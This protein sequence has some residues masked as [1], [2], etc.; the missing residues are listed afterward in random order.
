LRA[1]LPAQLAAT[2]SSGLE[3]AQHAR[4]QHR[5]TMPT[6]VGAIDELLGGG[7]PKGSLVELAARRSAG[8]FSIVLQTIAAATSAGEAAAL[9]DLGDHLDP[10]ELDDAGAELSRVLWVR[11]DTVKEAVMSAEILVATGFPLV[12]VDLGLRPR[13]AKVADAS[14]IRLARA[15]EA[16]GAAIL[17]SS[18]WP[19]CGTAAAMSLS[20]PDR[21][22]SWRGEGESP[23]LLTG[24]AARLTLLRSKGRHADVREGRVAAMTLR[25]VDE[26]AVRES[27]ATRQRIQ[28]ERAAGSA[29]PASLRNAAGAN[30]TNWRRLVAK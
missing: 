4:R 24:I 16:H 17:V 13:G 9:I 12:V 3:L 8:R 5:A 1:S 2:M 30:A 15:A 28:A 14:W 20:I 6:T 22:V 11:P 10:Q 29:A 21:R 26:I 25:S 23:R 18:P 19:L 7:L 27:G